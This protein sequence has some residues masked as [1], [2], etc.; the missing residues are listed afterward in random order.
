MIRG[1]LRAVVGAALLAAA[2]A[3]HAVA[4]SIQG[5]VRDTAGRQPVS[6]AVVLLLDGAGR[7]VGRNITDQAGR[8]R[9]DVAPGARTMRFLRIGYRPR[10]IA[11]PDALHTADV[12]VAMTALPTMLEAMH[13]TSGASCSP[14]GDRL[15]ALSLLEQARAG[16]LATVVAREAKPADMVRLRYTRVD[17]SE[18]ASGPRQKFH[19]DSSSDLKASFQAVRSAAEFVKDGF[20]DTLRGAD[21]LYGPDAE[22]LLD[23]A[24]SD[25]YCFELRKR[26][27]K[28][29]RAVGLGFVPAKTQANRIDIDGTVWID[30]VARRLEQIQFEYVGLDKSLRSLHLGGDIEFREL[31]NGVV[32]IDRWSLRI[33]TV[34]TD[35]LQ[36]ER[37]AK[38]IVREWLLAQES[39]GA[40]ATARWGDGSSWTAPLAE[41]N[42]RAVDHD[43]NPVGGLLVSVDSS[44]YHATTDAHGLA[45]LSYMMPGTYRGTAIDPALSAIGV[46]PSAPMQFV[47]KGAGPAYVAVRAATAV[48]FVRGACERDLQKRPIDAKGIWFIARVIDL[49]NRPVKLAEWRALRSINGEWVPITGAQGSTSSLGTAQYCGGDL[50]AGDEVRLES[51]S[52]L[53]DPWHPITFK[54][55]GRVTAALLQLPL[56]DGFE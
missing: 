48:D 14:R 49:D 31:A 30:T 16:L 35:T 21:I 6:G 32:L 41:V 42:V 9:I 22:T 24:F 27:G 40:V 53:Q 10:E 28:R 39:G 11:V 38:P 15:T 29:P 3:R 17:G 25:G 4:Q 46:R 55:A 13:V 50:H 44:D 37:D 8:Y 18:L 56:R 52:S 2:A 20:L 12:D 51:R 1:A 36:I 34:V 5:V 33:P 23:N 19:V 26:D 47:V 43:G 45:V 7:T 54:L